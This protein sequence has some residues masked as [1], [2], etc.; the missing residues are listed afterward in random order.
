[1]AVRYLLIVIDDEQPLGPQLKAARGLGKLP[2]KL[3]RELA[4]GMSVRHL[5]N[6]A[7][8]AHFCER[9]VVRRGITLDP[10][11]EP[12]CGPVKNKGEAM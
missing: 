12:A 2:W 8:A 9:Q 1:M 5:Q 11:H 3:L 4:G 10:T 6:L 7:D